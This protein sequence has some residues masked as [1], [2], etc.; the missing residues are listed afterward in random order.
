MVIESG[1]KVVAIEV[2]AA[3]RCSDKDLASLRVF[4]DRTP[5]CIAAV[6]AYNGE[7]PAQLGERLFCIP[8]VL[9]LS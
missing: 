3:S 7:K 2:K 5:Q 1:K 4:L 9:L 8:M 6:L